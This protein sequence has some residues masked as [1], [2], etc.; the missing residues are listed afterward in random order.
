MR[1]TMKVT[2]KNA[3]A[4]LRSAVC[5]LWSAVMLIPT[6]PVRA[7]SKLSGYSFIGRTLLFRRSYCF[8]KKWTIRLLDKK[9]IAVVQTEDESWNFIVQTGRLL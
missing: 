3:L 2:R 6:L 8:Q 7:A 5:I 9:G 1:Q 4:C